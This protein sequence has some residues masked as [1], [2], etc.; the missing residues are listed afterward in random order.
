M[1]RVVEF[2]QQEEHLNAFL[3]FPAQLY[4]RERITQDASQ[5]KA[6]LTGTHLFSKYFE[7]RKLLVYDRSGQVVARC[8]LTMYP[9][10]PVLYLG[11]FEA[12]PDSACSRLLFDHVAQLAHKMGYTKIVGPVDCSFWIR[13]RLKVDHFEQ[14]PYVSE[15]YNQ[16]YYLA[17][18]QENGFSISERYVSNR[19]PVVPKNQLPNSYERM[20]QRLLRKGY[21][22]V[23]PKKSEWETAINQ[24]YAMIMELYA[25]FPLFKTIEKEDFQ[26]YFENYKL[27]LD[28]SMVKMAYFR[29]EPVAFFIGLPD[30]GNLLYKKMTP[31]RILKLL[32]KKKSSRQ[33]I[34]SYLGVLKAHRGTGLGIAHE[35]M[36]ELDGR[37]ATSIGA[38]IQ[39]GKVTERY[40]EGYVT[41]TQNYVLL[42]RAV[43]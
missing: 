31:L 35:L 33:Y 21:T 29:G 16:E 9:D 24:V 3:A 1:Y 30:Y 4:S 19:Y 42:E 5:E 40:W 11:F 37:N 10:D 34:L 13:Y 15:P 36:H 23:S 39:K 22:I 2:E 14:M 18:F 27:I 41:Q 12:V 17:L 25:D 6:L 20:H 8:V 43:D 7:L 26:K 28:F 38:F 32:K